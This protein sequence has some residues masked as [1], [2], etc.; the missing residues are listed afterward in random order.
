MRTSLNRT[1]IRLATWPPLFGLMNRVFNTAPIILTLHRPTRLE[2]GIFGHDQRILRRYLT[3]LAHH[4]YR[5]ITVDAIDAWVHGEN[6]GDMTNT[7][8][9]TLDDGY[10]DQADLIRDVFLPMGVP[11]SMFLIT[12]FVDGKDWPWDAKINWLI[13][14]APRRLIRV[15]VGSIELK[16]GL[17]GD[18]KQRRDAARTFRSIVQ[19]ATPWELRRA[20]D[21]LAAAVDIPLPALPPACHQPITWDEARQLESQGIR[22]VHIQLIIMSS[23]A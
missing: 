10:R 2:L 4:R 21:D 5:T 1:V 23:A 9:F 16:L 13:L 22:L 20:I 3:F 8:A 19:Y 17:D 18:K 7:V 6:D 11:V 12:D 15:T 14:N